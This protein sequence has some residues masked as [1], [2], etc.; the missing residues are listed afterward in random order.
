MPQEIELICFD[1]TCVYNNPLDNLCSNGQPLIEL[2]TERTCRCLSYEEREE[3]E[4][5]V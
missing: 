5:E 1:E 2:E 3:E 4:E